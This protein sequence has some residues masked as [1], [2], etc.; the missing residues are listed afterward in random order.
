MFPG[1]DL[2]C[3]LRLPD[4]CFRWRHNKLFLLL[5]EEYGP[6]FPAIVDCYTSPPTW[7]WPLHFCLVFPALTVYYLR[8]VKA[9]DALRHRDVIRVACTPCWCVNAKIIGRFGD[10]DDFLDCFIIPAHI[11]GGTFWGWRHLAII[12]YAARYTIWC[13][14]PLAAWTFLAWCPTIYAHN[15]FRFQSAEKAFACGIIRWTSFT[16]HWANKTC[17]I[18]SFQPAWPAIMPTSVTVYQRSFACM[19]RWLI[20]MPGAFLWFPPLFSEYPVPSADGVFPD[21]VGRLPS[22]THRVLPPGKVR[23]VYA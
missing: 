7:V 4:H 11:V 20:L 5:P 2:I 13:K 6:A 8:F 12:L 1:E 9:I 16:G 22:A 21:S 3:E 17:C 10:A 23:Y 15:T 18:H 14:H 19:F